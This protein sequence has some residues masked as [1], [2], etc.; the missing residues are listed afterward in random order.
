MR[1]EGRRSGF[2]HRWHDTC[3]KICPWTWN[4]NNERSS[5]R[6]KW[7]NEEGELPDLPKGPN[8]GFEMQLLKTMRVTNGDFLPQLDQ[9]IETL[10][11]RRPDVKF[12]NIYQHCVFMLTQL[13]RHLSFERIESHMKMHWIK[14]FYHIKNSSQIIGYFTLAFKRLYSYIQGL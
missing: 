4:R 9:E 7:N 1:R 10:S 14:L 12:I 6:E 2:M 8:G 5:G 11:S 13:Q 3:P